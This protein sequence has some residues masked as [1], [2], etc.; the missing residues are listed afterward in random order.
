AHPH[1]D[2]ED[3]RRRLVLAADRH[4]AA[5]DTSRAI[6]LL[7]RARTAAAPG[8]ERATIL[9]R[10][11]GV[12]SSYSDAVA[13]YREALSEAEDDDALQATIHLSLASLMR[14]TEGIERGVEYAELAVRA[15]AHVGDAALRCRALA[16]YGLVYFGAGRG[17][18]T[19]EMEAAV[20]L[21]RSLAER[22]LA[23]G[24]T[25]VVAHQL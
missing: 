7:D 17:I 11:A 12:Q 22:P 19:A 21:E 9:A 2:V 13:L 16:A 24:R 18:P 10:L 20:S 3:A 15:A 14:F 4:H 25:H 8:V 6:A 1:V 5:G 23:E